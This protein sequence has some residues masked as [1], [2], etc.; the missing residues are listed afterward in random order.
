MVKS[1]PN[2]IWCRS[3]EY[4]RCELAEIIFSLHP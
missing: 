2:H 3:I 4:G 1:D